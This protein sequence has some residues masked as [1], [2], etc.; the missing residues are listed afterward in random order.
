MIFHGQGKLEFSAANYQDIAFVA[1][2][3]SLNWMDEAIYFTDDGALVNT[4][5]TQFE[6]LWIDTAGYRDYANIDRPAGAAVSDLPARPVHEL[7]AVPGLREPRDRRYGKELQKIDVVMYRVTDQRHTNKMIDAVARGV[8]VR[9]ITEPDNYRDP[10]YLW[11]SW[12]IDRMYMA[13][14]QIKQRTHAG[15][16]HQKSVILYGLGEVIFGSSN[17]TSA[18]ANS[19]AE[20]NMFYN[21]TLNKPWFF[22][23]F[24]DQF[25]RKW[26]DTANF[27]DF[28]PLPPTTPV[29]LSPATGQLGIGTSV[30]LKWEGGNW[31]HLY[32]IY[33]GTDPNPPLLASDVATGSPVNGTNET[34]VVP[35]L[36]PGTVYYWRVVGKTMANLGKSG[37]VW[38]FTTG[39]TGVRADGADR[40]HR[41]GHGPDP[42]PGRL[43]R[44]PRRDAVLRRAQRERLVGMV[45]DCRARCGRDRLHRQQRAR[46]RH[47]STTTG[48]VPGTPTAIRPTARW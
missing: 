24:V 11:H 27:G 15:L 22:Q 41:D 44:R 46:G 23:W 25:E 35:N 2:A 12:N 29:N 19:Q 1:N 48:C 20:H 17:W 6:T 8:P 39:G 36:V 30:T 7:R 40:R 28:T 18:S 10:K 33:F 4:F 26:N 21:P 31:A 13:G 9:L 32:D 47:R 38:S 43:D 14:V 5:I 37:P 3:P 16:M 45:A 34:Y 42:D